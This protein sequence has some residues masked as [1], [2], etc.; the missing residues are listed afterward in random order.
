MRINNQVGICR[1]N[2]HEGQ[3]R[4]SMHLEAAMHQEV[5][6][7]RVEATIA[8]E[9]SATP[10]M[11]PLQEEAETEN[12]AIGVPPTAAIDASRRQL[13]DGPDPL[14]SATTPEI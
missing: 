5:G 11:Y 10:E 9:T 6:A 12:G 3:K 7:F 14:H 1:E 4:T 2:H 8:T 13:V